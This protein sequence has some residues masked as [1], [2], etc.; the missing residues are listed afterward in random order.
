M[1]DNYRKFQFGTAFWIVLLGVTL[2]VSLSALNTGLLASVIAMVGIALVL[3]ILFGWLTV[4]VDAEAVE[5][6][7]GIGLVRKRIALDQIESCRIEHLAWYNGLGMR[8][9]QFGRVYTVTGRQIIVLD[10]VDGGTFGMGSAEPERLC[11]VIM[12]AVE[13]RR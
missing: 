2:L 5:A 13:E 3:G 8:Y 6:R 7:L 12:T 11:K 1:M 9:T 10:L 4:V